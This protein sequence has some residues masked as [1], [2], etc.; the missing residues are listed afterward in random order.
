VTSN[1][2]REMQMMQGGWLVRE[3]NQKDK[4]DIINLD[5]SKPC[6]NYPRGCFSLLLGG[7]Y[8]GFEMIRPR[9]RERETY[10]EREYTVPWPINL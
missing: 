10:R 2:L 1:N 7:Y 4:R 5:K 9:D 6:T 3:I 8:F